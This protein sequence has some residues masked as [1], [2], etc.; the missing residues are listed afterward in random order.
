MSQ[1]SATL[2]LM[3]QIQPQETLK[4]SPIQQILSS[5]NFMTYCCLNTTT[6][7]TKIQSPTSSNHYQQKI[8]NTTPK[9]TIPEILHLQTILTIPKKSTYKRKLQKFSTDVIEKIPKE[10]HQ[11]T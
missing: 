3:N 10:E 4:N 5:Q 11:N 7:T 9:E 2:S 6:T 8:I 1:I